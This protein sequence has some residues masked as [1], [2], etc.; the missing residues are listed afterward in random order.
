MAYASFILSLKRSQYKHWTI[1]GLYIVLALFLHRI[2]TLLITLSEGGGRL[3]DKWPYNWNE[4]MNHFLGETFFTDFEP[5]KHSPDAAN[6][7]VNICESHNALLC[8]FQIP[9]LKLD[10]VEIDVYDRS[11]EVIGTVQID[12][13]GFKPI[14][15]E[16]YQGP[17]RKKVKLPFPARHDKIRATYH[18]GYL[19]VYLH[20]LIGSDKTK[21]KIHIETSDANGSV[22]D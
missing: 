19:Y 5:L 21:K 4:W 15:L 13:K 14:H 12:Q 9:G 18:H 1:I 20:R 16:L 6:I 3:T 7:K 22:Y 8:I 17:V 10:E 11:L 2:T